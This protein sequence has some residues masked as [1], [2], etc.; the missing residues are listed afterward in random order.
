MNRKPVPQAIRRQL[1]ESAGR[2]CSN[3]GST[4]NLVVDHIFPVYRGGTNDPANLQILCSA[5]NG[6]KGIRTQ[7]EWERGIDIKLDGCT[8]AHPH[9]PALPGA[10]GSC[11]HKP[12]E[13][14][15][16][17][18]GGESV[19]VCKNWWTMDNLGPVE[20][21]I[22]AADPT[23]IAPSVWATHHGDLP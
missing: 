18:A 21:I 16:V 2:R 17:Y 19:E 14:V 20:R 13:Y 6:D 9:D 4:E 1:L 15:R 11:Q 3:C 12:L 8:P 10:Y 7:S 23:R 5:C 22:H